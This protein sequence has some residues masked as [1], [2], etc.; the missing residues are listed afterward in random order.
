[1]NTGSISIKKHDMECWS[2]GPNTFK[3]VQ[4]CSIFEQRKQN[5]KKPNNKELQ[6]LIKSVQ[7]IVEHTNMV[8]LERQL[9]RDGFN[10]L[11][12]RCLQLQQEVNDLWGKEPKDKFKEKYNKSQMLRT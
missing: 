1:M 7:Y 6:D 2:Y 12:K 10:R 3:H 8:E 11:E 9:Y 4:G 5:T